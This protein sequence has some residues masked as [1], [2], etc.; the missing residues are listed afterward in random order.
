M[1]NCSDTKSLIDAVS[2]SCP[3][4][5]IFTFLFGIIYLII[6]NYRQ[7]TVLDENWKLLAQITQIRKELERQ[8]T[9]GKETDKTAI[10]K[11]TSTSIEAQGVAQAAVRKAEIHIEAVKQNPDTS[12]KREEQPALATWTKS[13]RLMEERLEEEK[14]MKAR[15]RVDKLK[16]SFASKRREREARAKEAVAQK[17]KEASGAGLYHLAKPNAEVSEKKD[18]S[19]YF[20]LS[21]EQFTEFCN[22]LISKASKTVAEAKSG[23][24]LSGNASDME[25][26]KEEADIAPETAEESWETFEAEAAEE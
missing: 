3:C 21:D 26:A 25:K 13:E 12:E 24:E 18:D 7:A 20:E 19:K 16:E 4:F 10:E 17:S 9:A 22:V 23:S 8:S 15:Q 11:K 1:C 6:I 2:G 5:E 14:L